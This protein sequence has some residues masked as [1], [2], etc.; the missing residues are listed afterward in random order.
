MKALDDL[1]ARRIY[2]GVTGLSRAGKTVFVTSLIHNLLRADTRAEECPLRGLDVFDEDRL[3]GGSLRHDANAT[4]PEFPYRKA[5]QAITGE[6]P[7]WPEPTRGISRIRIDLRFRRSDGGLTGQAATRL[8]L[9]TGTLQLEIVDYPGEWL[10]DLPML[11]MEFEDWSAAMLAQAERGIR[12]ELSRDWLAFVRQR[13][14]GAPHDEEWAE[15]A[16][17]LYAEY[18]RACSERHLRNLQPGRFL[19]PADL[20]GASVLRFCPLPDLT[21][22]GE[23]GSLHATF[24][25]K[26]H[27][28]QEKVVRA[29]YRKHFAGL[30]RQVVLVDALSALNDGQE[31]FEDQSEA[32][33]AIL[34][35]FRHGKY[36]LLGW[37]MGRRISK[38]LF[39][40]TKAD[41]V[42]RGDRL[43]LENLTRRMLHVLD[44]NNTIKTSADTHVQAIA[45]IRATKDTR[46]A[47]NGREIL[48]GR[49]PD[50]PHEFPL[51]PGAIPLDFPPDWAALDYRFWDF[52][53]DPAP[54]WQHS[55]FPTLR[56]PEVLNFL[57]GEDLK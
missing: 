20:R 16:S 57:I 11:G 27:D 3:I 9:T 49:R 52:Q 44:E 31:A 21:G 39:A 23:P 22:R 32:L 36:S 19:H 4:V 46:R 6:S 41:H 5:L 24:R 38:V 17:A 26:F 55:G 7:Q 53:P 47:D 51:E 12:A 25:A 40:A 14:P 2:L 45:A 48:I 56:M 42:I 35:S 54:S 50:D 37:L 43:H 28:Y 30:D 29:F 15:Q 1:L 34:Q 18:L 33:A 13:P 8:G 10:V